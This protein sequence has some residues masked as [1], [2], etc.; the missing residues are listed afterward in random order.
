MLRQLLSSSALVLSALMESA[1]PALIALV[2]DWRRQYGAHIDVDM[3]A[4][5]GANHITIRSA[6]PKFTYAKV[7][8]FLLDSQTL[9]LVSVPASVVSPKLLAV[10]AFSRQENGCRGVIVAPCVLLSY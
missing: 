1:Q 4:P 10:A 5:P 7:S 3:F 8:Q 9:I 2:R 6:H